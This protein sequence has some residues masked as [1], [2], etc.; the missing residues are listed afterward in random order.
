[1]NINRPKA[2]ISNYLMEQLE[3]KFP[4]AT[5]KQ[6]QNASKRMGEIV[7]FLVNIPLC[8]SA[9]VGIGFSVKQSSEDIAK[10]NN[11]D[12]DTV[13][14]IIFDAAHLFRETA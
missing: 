8:E 12:G 10:E 1:M 6:L 7:H 4:S 14:K 5:K 3:K 13:C 9:A 2:K 11:L